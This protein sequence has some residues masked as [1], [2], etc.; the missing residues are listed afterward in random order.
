LLRLQFKCTFFGTTRLNDSISCSVTSPL[1]LPIALV[2]NHLILLF[3]R[4]KH[5]RLFANF[6][7]HSTVEKYPCTQ[8]NNNHEF[9]SHSSFQFD[10]TDDDGGD[11]GEDVDDTTTPSH[12]VEEDTS[13]PTSPTVDSI[14]TC[15]KCPINCTNCN[16]GCPICKF[17]NYHHPSSLCQWSTTRLSRPEPTTPLQYR[18]EYIFAFAPSDQQK[19]KCHRPDP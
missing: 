16:H 4:L 14:S 15:S 7:Y 17:F 1:Y 18:K 11:G 10:S 2:R 19:I 9:Q 3:S 8:I 6:K 13:P 5:N 12:F